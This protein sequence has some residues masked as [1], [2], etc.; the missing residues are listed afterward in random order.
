M[1]GSEGFE[2]IVLKNDEMIPLGAQ[3]NVGIGENQPNRVYQELAIIQSERVGLDAIV[4]SQWSTELLELAVSKY[5][6]PDPNAVGNLVV[7]GHNYSNSAFFG[8]LQLFEIGDLV[9][10]TD[11]TGKTLEYSVYEISMIKPNDL[12]TLI[13]DYEI[14]L[15]MVT[16]DINS[17]FWLAVKCKAET[18]Q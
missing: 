9:K 4:V 1:E 10:L 2:D 11:K 3:K 13:A 6:G 16:S 17:V 8:S 15:T 12:D 14:T 7:I 5:Q 18:T